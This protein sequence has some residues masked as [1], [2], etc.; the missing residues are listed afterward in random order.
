MMTTDRGSELLVRR[1]KV[2]MPAMGTLFG[3][4]AIELARG[5]GCQVWDS[6]GRRYLDCLSGIAV[7]SLGHC[8]PEVVAAATEQL[9]RFQ[10]ST[11]LFLNELAVELAEKLLEKAP[12]SIARVFFC[13]DGSGAIDGAMVAA[14]R[15]TGRQRFLAFSEGLHG[16]TSL[17]MAA[18]GLPIWR[19]DP[20]GP[21]SDVVHLPPPGE[22]TEEESLSLIREAIQQHPAATFAA[23]ILEP[24]LGNGGIIPLGPIFLRA[25]HRILGENGILLL[26]DEVQTG[27]CRTGAWFGIEESK[28]EPDLMCVAKGMANGLP[29]AAWLCSEQVARAMTLPVASTFGGN[30][31][32]M[33]AA[34]KVMEIMER[35][36]LANHAAALG[37]RFLAE[38][39]PIAE[40]DP[41]L[42]LPRGR[43]LMIG[44]PTSDGAFLDRILLALKCRGIIAGKSGR[45][46]NILTFL[47]PLVLDHTQ[48]GEILENLRGALEEVTR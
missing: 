36:H 21:A 4:E 14:R 6:D 20:C 38:L 24:V 3:E 47:P 42:G 32:A 27:F 2:F 22:I 1:R 15:A 25:L 9:G 23:F 48:L 11:S 45:H 41:N 30:Q 8:H 35:D 5:E 28:V 46:R 37:R 39:A 16:R 18:T 44:I 34:L 13:A 26:V 40:S 10:H 43:G 33:A 7:T 17:T 29:Q 19:N 12:P 31:V